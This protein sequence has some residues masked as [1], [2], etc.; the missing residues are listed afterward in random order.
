MFPYL[1]CPMFC[2]LPAQ[3]RGRLVYHYRPSGYDKGGHCVYK[4]LLNLSC[5]LYFSAVYCGVSNGTLRITIIL[6]M[7]AK[8]AMGI[9]MIR[10]ANTRHIKPAT[11]SGTIILGF[12]IQPQRHGEQHGSNKV[13]A[14]RIE[15]SPCLGNLFVYLSCAMVA[16]DEPSA[17]LHTLEA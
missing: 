15:I 3:E 2:R 13:H 17:F 9:H 8:I 11:E 10:P 1:L 5:R 6:R 4:R 7:N 12:H 16:R 14:H